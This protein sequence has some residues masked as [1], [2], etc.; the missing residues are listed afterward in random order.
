MERQRLLKEQ[1]EKKKKEEEELIAKEKEATA[2]AVAALDTIL[3]SGSKGTE[4]VS[5]VQGSSIEITGKALIKQVLTRS[6]NVTK[7]NWWASSEYGDALKSLLSGE[8]ASKK[9][10]AALYAV[11]EFCFEQKYP[12]IEFDGKD[13]RMIL[14]I[15]KILLNN[16]F[17]EDEVFVDWADDENAPDDNGRTTAIVHST[18]FVS[19]IRDALMEEDEEEYEDEDEE[20]EIDAP[21]EFIPNSK[22][23]AAQTPFVK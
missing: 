23:V 16:N 10:L 22:R 15:F 2:A 6:D 7:S 18:S 13:T 5:K 17:I 9:Q 20:D 21:A 4:L 12:L 19:E 14:A 3:E 8:D 1:A 11:Q